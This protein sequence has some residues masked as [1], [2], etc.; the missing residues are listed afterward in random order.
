MYRDVNRTGIDLPPSLTFKSGPIF[1]LRVA[2]IFRP[3]FIEY[4]WETRT[5]IRVQSI[6][7]GKKTIEKYITIV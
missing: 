3:F 1:G 2:G 5:E 6:R 4:L 7:I